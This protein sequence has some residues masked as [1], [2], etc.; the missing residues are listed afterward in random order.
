MIRGGNLKDHITHNIPI[1][2]PKYLKNCFFVERVNTCNCEII[3]TLGK[4]NLIGKMGKDF[5]R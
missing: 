3:A 4:I 1:K 5:N 2:Y